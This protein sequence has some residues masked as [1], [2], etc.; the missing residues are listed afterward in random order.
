M[1]R[2][3][4]PQLL[5]ASLLALSSCLP[6]E[7]SG[8]AAA[9]EARIAA[10]EKELAETRRHQ[11]NSLTLLPSRLTDLEQTVEE[12]QKS[13]VKE[14]S[15]TLARN[16]EYQS[17]LQWLL[18][19]YNLLDDAVISGERAV[20]LS[21]TQQEL[22]PTLTRYGTFLV[23]LTGTDKK[24]GG[25]DLQLSLTNAT[26]FR[27]H[28]F[29]LH[30]DFGPKSPVLEAKTTTRQRMEALDAWELS[31]VKYEQAYQTVL[32]PNERSSV[33][34][35]VPAK[36]LADLE[37]IRLWMDVQAVSLPATR[38]PSAVATF[39]ASRPDSSILHVLPSDA[40]TFYL[41]LE[42]VV[43][44]TGTQQVQARFGNPF[45]MTIDRIRI[46]GTLGRKSPQAGPNDPPDKRELDQL[47]WRQSRQT[48]SKEI[49]S[50]LKPMQWN[51][52]TLDLPAASTADLEQVECRVDVLELHLLPG[53]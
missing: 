36:R 41:K 17:Q 46:H 37:F 27:I 44:G 43:P 11:D 8:K 49:R 28:K 7:P 22:I 1:R 9:L 4:V 35:H 6:I 30:G 32:E 14:Q 15:E 10:L 20:G 42:K 25:Y 39:D 5:A 18:R 19:L 12:A 2:P 40:G 3:P 33:V 47:Q 24:D 16:Q 26:S 51:E 53:K 21:V 45:G 31:L 48:F 50:T 38:Q 23:K 13:R 29:R 34:L 52:I